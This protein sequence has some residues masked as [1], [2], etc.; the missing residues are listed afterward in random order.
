MVMRSKRG[1]YCE[2]FLPMAP[3]P[4]ADR[5]KYVTRARNLGPGRGSTKR[6]GA[7]VDEVS[8]FLWTLMLQKL[9]AWG[10]DP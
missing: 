10:E 4:P 7:K 9:I 6:R 5:L 8:P 3:Y 1:L 2:D